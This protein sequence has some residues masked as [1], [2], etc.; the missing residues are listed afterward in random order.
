MRDLLHGIGKGCLQDAI[1]SLIAQCALEAFAD[2]QFAALAKY[3]KGCDETVTTGNELKGAAKHA[4]HDL[5]LSVQR[6]SECC[7]A[8]YTATQEQESRRAASRQAAAWRFSALAGYL[9]SEGGCKVVGG[10]E[11]RL[12]ACLF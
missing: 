9:A 8:S 1:W 5:N 10:C 11:N 7:T 2:T 3:G 6:K 12:E 4:H